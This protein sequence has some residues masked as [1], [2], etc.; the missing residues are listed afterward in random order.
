MS[1]L[2][3]AIILGPPEAPGKVTPV[4]VAAE[5][6]Q[7]SWTVGL[8]GGSELSFQVLYS[9]VGITAKGFIDTNIEDP[10]YRSQQIFTVTGAN[11]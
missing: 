1:N 4:A 2:L 5:Q 9:T 3:F 7:I 6:I 8:S 10:V 11:H